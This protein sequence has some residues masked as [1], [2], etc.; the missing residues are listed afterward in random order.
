[1]DKEA[2]KKE[3]TW[4]GKI[5]LLTTTEYLRANTNTTLCGTTSSILQTD[6][7]KCTSTNYL[8]KGSSSWWLL[9]PGY[10]TSNVFFARSNGLV[11]DNSASLSYGVRPSFYLKSGLTFSGEGTYASPYEICD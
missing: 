4:N 9:S 5:A 3:S 6:F 8:F 1:M 10:N 7:K 2:I 11:Y